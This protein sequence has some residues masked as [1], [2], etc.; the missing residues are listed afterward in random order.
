MIK[1][2]EL[3]EPR[4]TSK[5]LTLVNQYKSTAIIIAGGTDL[6]PEMKRGTVVAPVLITIRDIPE[7][8]RITCH[9]NK[10][11]YVGA[12]TTIHEIETSPV[13]KEYYPLLVQAASRLGSPQVRNQATLGGNLCQASP[14]GDMI[15]PSI[16][17]GALLNVRSISGQRSIRCEKFFKGPG[18]T[19]LKSGEVLTE[20]FFPP[21]NKNCHTAFVKFGRRESV[22][23]AIVNVAVWVRINKNNMC[24]DVR[25]VL[26]AVAPTTMRAHIAE[27]L[28]KNKRLDNNLIQIAGN[29]VAEEVQPI[30]DLR[31]SADYRMEMSKIITIR[32]LEATMTDYLRGGGEG[33]LTK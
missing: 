3:F 14:A 25:I 7:L 31:A 16:A 4:S 10:G 29:K 30:S 15:P 18:Q 32:A 19:V 11:L 5:L 13:L 9:P 22:D 17:L 33:K 12:A 27:S 6:L 2:F 23:L 24:D 1:D 21:S 8:R 20:I 28:L 26:G